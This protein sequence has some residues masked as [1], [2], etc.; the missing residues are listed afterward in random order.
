MIEI[1]LSIIF[2]IVP[3]SVTLFRDLSHIYKIMDKLKELLKATKP[4]TKLVEQKK[5]IEE[6][7]KKYEEEHREEQLKKQENR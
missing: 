2:F 1:N 4:T 7:N 3:S 6:Q 5:V